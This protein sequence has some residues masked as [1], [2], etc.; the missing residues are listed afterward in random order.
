ML[1]TAE[2]PTIRRNGNYNN[3]YSDNLGI[4][5]MPR[6]ASYC[7]AHTYNAHLTGYSYIV[8]DTYHT[9][10]YTGNLCRLRTQLTCGHIDSSYSTRTKF[11]T[12]SV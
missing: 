9:T 4:G 7:L 3:K 12:V 10:P 6:M 5:R 8:P 11:L 1:R 2:I